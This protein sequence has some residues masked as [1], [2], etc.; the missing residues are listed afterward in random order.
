MGSSSSR[1][2]AD[3][4]RDN[5]PQAET[6]GLPTANVTNSISQTQTRE[7][8]QSRFNLMNTEASERVRLPRSL[9]INYTMNHNLTS[10]SVS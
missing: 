7:V 6:D 5:Q 8:N 9:D 2:D 1:C 3:D 10:S 4:E